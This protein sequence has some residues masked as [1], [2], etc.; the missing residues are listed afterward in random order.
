MGLIYDAVGAPEQWRTVLDRI[1][2]ELGA[3]AAAL[4]V[5]DAGEQRAELGLATGAFDATALASYTREFGAIDPAPAAF[6]RLKVGEAGA[7]DRMFSREMRAHDP[8]F[9][10]FFRPHGLEECLGAT[11]LRDEDRAA[12]IGIQRAPDRRAFDDGDIAS[13]ERLLPHIQRAL[14]LHRQ[15]AAVTGMATALAAL[16]DELP[17][18]MIVLDAGGN[19]VHLNRAAQALVA[20]DDGIAIDRAGQVTLAAPDAKARF[21]ALLHDVLHGNPASD[22]QGAGGALRVRRK[23][24]R[25]PYTMLVT[26]RPPALADGAPGREEMPGGALPSG[27][28][29]V[30]HD[31]DRLLQI[32]AA[33]VQAVFGL[34]RREAELTAAL[35]AGVTPTQFAAQA[36]V[37]VNT[38]RFHLKSLYAKTETRGQADLIRVV[39]AT[40]ASLGSERHAPLW[41]TAR[42]R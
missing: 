5:L 8:F 7:T 38:V 3:Q 15:F 39:M 9:N 30:I 6:A 34:T 17:S 33:V 37:S 40:I 42:K 2:R 27:A 22:A 26:P 19:V 31:P 23:H 32:P 14:Q 35:C 4:V 29:V 11:V 21:A 20:R 12:Q 16:V 25:A 1:A 13:L 36:G 10:E 18:G 24:A 41:T 28:L